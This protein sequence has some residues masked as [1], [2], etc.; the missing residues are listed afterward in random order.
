[1]IKI[2]IKNK[3]TN[4]ITNS[5]TFN[6]ETEKNLW[7]NEHINKNSFGKKAGFYSH[8]NLTINE[9]SQEISREIDI[10]GDTLVQI[11]DQYEIITE[12]ITIEYQKEVKIKDGLKAQDVGAKVIA[13][14]WAINE[15]RNLDIPTLELMLADQNLANIERLLWNGSLKTAKI[16][17]QN[18]NNVFFSQDEKAEVLAIINDSGL[19]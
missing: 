6:N 14:V 9:L 13:K 1:M 7:L 17:I 5:A 18:L 12:D 10:N 8:A 3:Q 15:S 4:Q 11:P 19:V 16:L 2:N